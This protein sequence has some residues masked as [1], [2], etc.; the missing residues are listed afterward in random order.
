MALEVFWGSGSPFAW[1][2]LLTLEVKQLPYESRLLE[3]SKKQHKS[4]EFL[5]LNPRGKVPVLKDGDF[6]VYESLAIMKYLDDKYPA[7]RI[8]GED[9]ET[10]ARIMMGVC[11]CASYIEQ[12][13]EDVVRPIFA[14][15]AAE[16]REAIMSAAN[17]LRDEYALLNA[18]LT[19]RQ[20]LV[21]GSVTAAD[22]VLYPQAAILLRALGKDE[23]AS[24]DLK[25]APFG[26]YFPAVAQ[27]MRAVEALPGFERTYPPH[28]R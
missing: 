19:G 28:W 5:R 27:W 6:V 21:G 8:F 22:I 12:P 4:P 13:T 26:D 14:R 16:Q 23:A 25:L 17:T 15:G 3:F 1:R 24:L 10:S 11:E 18:K 20:W 2:V 7:L 9:P